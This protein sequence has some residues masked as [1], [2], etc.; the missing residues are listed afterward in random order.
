M[1]VHRVAIYDQ[2]HGEMKKARE[3]ILTTADG[4]VGWLLK[5]IQT[6]LDTL[7]ASE[8]MVLA[9]EIASFV[10]DVANRRGADIATE[11][12]WSV[13]SIPGRDLGTC[14]VVERPKRCRRWSWQP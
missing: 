1:P 4:E 14:R 3:R 7:T 12:G 9:F 11:A 2:F 6:D 10:D 13:R 5:F 8:W